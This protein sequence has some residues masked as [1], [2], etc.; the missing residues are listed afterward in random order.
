MK[1]TS[2][3]VI[4]VNIQRSPRLDVLKKLNEKNKH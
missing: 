1:E 3:I 2:R 4:T